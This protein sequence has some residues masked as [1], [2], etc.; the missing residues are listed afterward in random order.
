MDI[1]TTLADTWNVQSL[2][3]LMANCFQYSLAKERGC[4]TDI[5]LWSLRCKK[6][7]HFLSL[8]FCYEPSEQSLWCTVY[9]HGSSLLIAVQFL[10]HITCTVLSMMSASRQVFALILLHERLIM[11]NIFRMN[12]F[13]N[14]VTCCPLAR[15]PQPL[16]WPAQ[17]RHAVAICTKISWLFS[18]EALKH[19]A[20]PL[21]A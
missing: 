14:W 20:M 10:R 15:L 21:S 13:T 9:P 18:T 16:Q 17:V 5:C 6:C 11:R 2:F 7:V 19:N 4:L 8:V 1:G 12:V 3:T